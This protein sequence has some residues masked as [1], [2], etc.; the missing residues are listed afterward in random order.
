MTIRNF[1]ELVL[2]IVNKP[3]FLEFNIHNEKTISDLVNLIENN[4]QIQNIPLIKV[5]TKMDVFTLE[6]RPED[7]EMQP[8]LL[9]EN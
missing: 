1:K 6:I 7:K 2:G 4:S 5:F 3:F 8:I 9:M